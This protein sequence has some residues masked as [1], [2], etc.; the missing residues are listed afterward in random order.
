M[1]V[2]TFYQSHEHIDLL[3]E[4]PKPASKTL[5]DWYKSQSAPLGEFG[6]TIKRC[7]PIFDAMTAGYILTLPCDIYVNAT[8]P[9]KLEYFVPPNVLDNLQEDLFAEHLPEQ[10]S[11]YPKNTS[12]YHKD[13]LRIDPFYTVGT[14]K[15]YSCLFVQ[16][17][18]SD[19]SP[20]QVFTAMIDTDAFISNGHYSFFVEKGFNGI[21][22]QGTPLVQVIPFKRDSFVSKVTPFEQAKIIL[23]KQGTRLRST[24]VNGYKNKFR[25]LKQ[26]K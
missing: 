8:N 14:E 6:S 22:K 21:I 4:P 1:S 17:I 9:A 20:L 16:P 7:M 19:S 13:V 11:D 12:R 25:S 24:F 10:L 18:H 3:V 5:P 23:K 26:Y 15:G 2:I